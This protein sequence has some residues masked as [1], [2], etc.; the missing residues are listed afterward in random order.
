MIKGWFNPHASPEKLLE[1]YCATGKEHYL[2][3]LVKQ[4]HQPLY[5]YLLTQSDQATAQDL[6][7]STWLKV[8]NNRHRQVAHSHVKSWLFTIARNN[9]IDE[10]RRQQRWQWH[11][12]EP[13]HL[14]SETLEQLVANADKLSCFNQVITQ[15]P[16]HQR[17]AFLFQQEGFTIDEICQLTDAN[18]ET[19]KSRLRYARNNLKTVLGPKL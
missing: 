4:F 3:L 9:L 19:V 14:P 18:F 5:H 8:I 10:L 12:L 17:E 13:E 11:E 2:T 1:N 16:F 6:L 7:Q 15:L